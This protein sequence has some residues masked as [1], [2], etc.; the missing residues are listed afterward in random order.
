M[1]AV[2]LAHRHDHASVATIGRELVGLLAPACARVEIAGSVRRRVRQV[3]DLEIVV[4]A[5][6]GERPATQSSL[7]AAAVEPYNLLHSRVLQL[8]ADGVLET[9]KTGTTTHVPWTPKPDGKQWRLHFEGVDVDLFLAQ[10]ESWGV[11]LW[12]RTGSAKTHTGANGFVPNC[13]ARWKALQAGQARLQDNLFIDGRGHRHA[14]ATEAEVF[15]LLRMP[16]IEPP[17]REDANL[18][19]AF[20][21]DWRP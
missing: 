7:F 18:P 19:R 21:L 11:T 1:T 17:R 12:Q 8:R 6:W 10:P 14:C 2:S 16:F 5:K 15:A 20:P 9:L 13:L 4:L 3:K